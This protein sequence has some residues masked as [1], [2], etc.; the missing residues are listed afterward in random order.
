MNRSDFIINSYEA[1]AQDFR[2]YSE[3]RAA[4]LEAIDRLIVKQIS[5]NARSLLDIGSGDGVRAAHLARALKLPVA[6][7]VEPSPKMAA[8]CRRQPVSDVWQ[9][10]AEDLP[11]SDQRFDAVTCL[12]NILGL[13]E[14]RARRIRALRKM[15]QLLAP[16]GRIFL[17]VNNRYNARAYGWLPVMGRMLKD[18]ARPS[19]TSGDI[20]F[21]WRVGGRRIKSYGHVFTPREVEGLMQRA[22]LKVV[23]R[24][25][26]DYSSGRESRT[27]FGGQL[28]YE[29]SKL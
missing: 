28:F 1:L 25:F 7:L 18:L 9:V 5:E 8:L 15:G 4:Y 27:G 21:E 12:W 20:S 16:G 2:A 24:R 11:E 14:D 29:L 17:D 19:E 10:R 6:V 26:V 3:R 13:I 22:G 23:S